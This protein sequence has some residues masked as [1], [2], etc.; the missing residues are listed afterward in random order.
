MI[1]CEKVKPSFPRTHTSYLQDLDEIPAFIWFMHLSLLHLASL[2][3]NSNEEGLNIA[4]NEPDNW[5]IRMDAQISA[6]FTNSLGTAR[7]S[8]SE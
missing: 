3:G 7:N 6:V 5:R 4:I 8:A 2:Y 1:R